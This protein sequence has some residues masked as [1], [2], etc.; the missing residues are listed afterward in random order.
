MGHL[1]IPKTE[2]LAIAGKL[3][4]GITFEHILDDIR[5][6]MDNC[7]NRIHLTTR[8]DIAN[9]QQT[10]G[11]REAQYHK[12]DATSVMVWVDTMKK[13]PSSPVLLYK[14]QGQPT[15]PECWHLRDQ[16]FMLVLQSPTQAEVLRKCGHNQVICID[17]THGTNSYDFYLTTILAVDEFGEGYPTA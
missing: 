15:K 16:D 10:Y 13:Q 6:G 14:Q 5:N 8:K 17:D 11:L 4:Q 7:I 2:R 3:L 1:R 9:I 12:D